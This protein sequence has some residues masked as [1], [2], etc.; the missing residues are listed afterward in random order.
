MR[1]VGGGTKLGWGRPIDAARAERRP[2][3][4][5]SSSTT[6]ATSRRS[7]RPAARWPRRARRSPSEGQMLALDPPDDGATIGG[8]VATGD[9]GPLRHRYGGAA[10]PRARRAGRAARRLA[11]A[12]RSKVIKNVAGYD[13]AKLMTGAYGTLG[14]VTEVSV[15]L[16]PRAARVADR[17]RAPRRPARAGGRRA[18]A[19]PPPARGRAPGRAL[20]GRRAARC[21]SSS[22]ARRRA[23][24]AASIDGEVVEDDEALWAAQRAA[25]RGPVVAARLDHPAGPGRRAGAPRAST[26]PSAWRAP[27]SAWP[28]CAS[29]RPT[30][31][32]SS[33]LRARLGRVRAARRPRGAAPRGRSLGA[34]ERRAAHAPRQGALRPLRHPATR[35]CCCTST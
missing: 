11:G 6:R 12:R 33:A 35:A 10:R 25:Q 5:R 32:S 16:H 2:S 14:V 18:R 29:R 3:S 8:V 22:A 26:A 9:S 1:I 24:R 4:T 28:G 15:R 13:L 19:D 27:P 23:E 34:A 20:G 21:S 31:S 30:P 7:C 17:R